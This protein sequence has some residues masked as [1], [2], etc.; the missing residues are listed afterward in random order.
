MARS[1]GL[2]VLVNQNKNQGCSSLCW[3]GYARGHESEIDNP[4]PYGGFPRIWPVHPAGRNNVSKTGLTQFRLY[5]SKPTNLNG[6][7]DFMKFPSSYYAGVSSSPRLVI[8][9][10]LP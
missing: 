9:S 2:N 10:T 7:A 8:T 4:L 6:E 3:S 1:L 5:F